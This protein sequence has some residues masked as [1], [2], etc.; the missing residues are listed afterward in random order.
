MD[1]DIWNVVFDNEYELFLLKKQ[2]ESLLLNNDLEYNL[3]LNEE[4]PDIL[5]SKLKSMNIIDI[6][7][8]ANFKYNIFTLED[9]IDLNIAKNI[10]PYRL[11]QIIKLQVYKK[12]KYD[13]HIILDSK[14]IVFKK[15]ALKNFQ[16]MY[17]S[18]EDPEFD[19]CYEY[20]IARWNNS[21]KIKIRRPLTPYLFKSGI[22]S[23]LEK[24]FDSYNEYIEILSNPFPSS[25]DNS[26]NILSEFTMYNVFEKCFDKNYKDTFDNPVMPKFITKNTDS[27]K[28]SKLHSVISIHRNV[29]KDIGYIKSNEIIDY[30]LY[31]KLDK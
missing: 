26:N 13:N 14:N 30:F 11:Q 1:K 7:E 21:K 10:K 3:V 24:N 18:D 22:L 4:N 27:K 29:V 19:S 12:S 6:L 23:M 2:V 9:M 28:L 16:P 5:L 25:G 15:D 17:E 31:K 8:T 20:C